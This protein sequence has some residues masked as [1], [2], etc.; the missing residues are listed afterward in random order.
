MPRK[1]AT[2]IADDLVKFCMTAKIEEAAALLATGTAIVKVR[3]S[4]P[5][6]VPLPLGRP[7]KLAAVPPTGGKLPV[8]S[9]TTADTVDLAAARDRANQAIGAGSPRKPREPRPM[10]PAVTDLPAPPAPPPSNAPLDTD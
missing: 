3:A 4:K 5:A 9:P 10:R 8:K 2:S 7:R 1:K 6:D